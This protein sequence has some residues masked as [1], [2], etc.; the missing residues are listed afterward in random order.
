MGFPGISAITN[1]PTK[2]GDAGSIPRSA[3]S[4]GEGTHSSI[5]TWDM[6]RTEAPGGLLSMGFLK[7]LDTT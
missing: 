6:P 4:S 2:A 7:K 1:P 3:R 5:L